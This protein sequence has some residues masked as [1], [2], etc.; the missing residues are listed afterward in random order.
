MPIKIPLL[1]VNITPVAGWRLCCCRLWATAKSLLLAALLLPLINA[2]SPAP[3]AELKVASRSLQSASLSRDG[4]HALIGS[5]HQGGSYWQ[6]EP[7]ERLYNWNH[8]DDHSGLLLH[9]AISSDGGWAITAEQ[10][11]LVLWNTSSGEPVAYWRI[12]AE[13]RALTLGRF[14]NVALL[15]LADGRA[16]LYDVRRGA[17]L[18]TF[19]HDSPVNAVALS[20]DLSLALTGSDD[21]MAQ[22]WRSQTGQLLQQREF[23]TSIQQVSLSP[24]GQRAL[25]SARYDRVELFNSASGELIWQLP[26]GRERTRLGITLSAARFSDDGDYLLTGR[27]DGRVQ[28]WD[29]QAQQELYHWQMPKLNPWQPNPT[30]VL[31]VSFTDHPERYRAVS[32]NGFIYTLS[33]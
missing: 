29:I 32:G 6:V 10:Q 2:C 5:T 27:P 7:G 3:E 22:L 14:G 20:D 21:H 23:A 11:T 15:G 26:L 33:Y 31:E 12:S 19:E 30:S 18:G 16:V 25:V 28:L 8:S 9:S 17:T 13:I 24:D 4:R 1:P